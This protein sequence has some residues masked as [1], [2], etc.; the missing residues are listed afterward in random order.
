MDGDDR[1]LGAV[2]VGLDGFALVAARQVEG[3][4]WLHAQTTTTQTGCPGCGVVATPHGRRA[5]VVRDVALGGR[6][7]RLV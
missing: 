1:A 2:V 7:A 3:E 5:T 6:L 4:V